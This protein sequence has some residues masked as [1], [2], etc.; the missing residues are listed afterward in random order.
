M[1]FNFICVAKCHQFSLVFSQTITK[2]YLFIQSGFDFL[3]LQSQPHFLKK[4]KNN[5]I[6]EHFHANTNTALDSRG[7]NKIS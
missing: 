1:E 6:R 7:Q 5:M 2:R 4:G 3:K